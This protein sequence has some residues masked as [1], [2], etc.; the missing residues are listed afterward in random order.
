MRGRNRRSVGLFKKRQPWILFSF[1]YFPNNKNKKKKGGL[2]KYPLTNQVYYYI[3]QANISYI[4]IEKRL[5][6]MRRDARTCWTVAHPPPTQNGRQV[7]IDRAVL[8]PISRPSSLSL[9]YFLPTKSLS[10][11][12]LIFKVDRSTSAQQPTP[13]WCCWGYIHEAKLIS[14]YINSNKI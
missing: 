14:T 12:R 7:N 3:T 13:R 1:F 9:S 8:S 4:E 11:N 10:V 2:Y 6:R 5:L